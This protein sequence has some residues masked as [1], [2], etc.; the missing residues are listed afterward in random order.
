MYGRAVWLTCMGELCEPEGTELW[1][2]E[3]YI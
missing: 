2:N 3:I 1:E